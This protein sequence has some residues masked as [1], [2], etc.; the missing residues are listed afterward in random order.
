MSAL[1]PAT[2]ERLMKILALLGSDID[3]ERAAAA[4]AAHRLIQKSG[5]SWE[6]L[7]MPVYAP[8]APVS[9][10]PPPSSRKRR[11]FSESDLRGALRDAAVHGLSKHWHLLNAEEQSMA[12][13][14]IEAAMGNGSTRWNKYWQQKLDYLSAVI[15]RR[16]EEAAA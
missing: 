4:L 9:P 13:T 2:R 6:I 10:P 14:V 5:M 16:K 1:T 15:R 12:R 11:G 3:G 7:L 8:A